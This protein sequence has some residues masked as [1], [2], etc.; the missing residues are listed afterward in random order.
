MRRMNTD[1][2]EYV[3][4]DVETNGLK[5]K[6]DDLLSISFY[7]PDDGKEYNRFL[8]LELNRKIV[9]THIN[10]ITEKDLV[11]ATALTQIEFNHIVDEFELE[12]RIIL[13]YAGGNFDESFLCEYMRRH[14]ISGFE[15]L[16]F[17]NFKKNIISSR[18]SSG[19][20]TKDNLC[21]LFEIKGV[22]AVHSSSN[23]CKLEWEL[24]KKMDGYY[25]LVTE[26]DGADNVFKLNEDYIIP[27]SLLYSHPNLSRILCERP[28]IECKSTTVKTFEIEA[29]GIEKFP[30]NFTGM[31]I[32]HLINSMLN[33]DIQDSRPFLLK[34]KMK[35]DFIGKIPNG[36]LAIPMTF[37]PDGTVTTLNKADKEIEKRINSTNNNLKEQIRPLV[38]FIRN[39][40]FKN[41]HIMSQELVIN[42][43]NNI[44]ALCDLSTTKT[45]L[46]IKTDCSDSLAYKEQ[47]FYEAKGRKIYHLK[48]EWIKDRDTN[49]LKK[50]IFN[51]VLVDVHIGIPDSLNWF[52]GK[53]EG[54]R[55]KRVAE[56]KKYLLSS[57][58]SLVSFKNIST[59]IKLQCKICEYEWNIRYVTLMKKIPD[60]PRCQVK[61]ISKKRTAMSGEERGK[62]R[63]DNYYEKILQKSN[64]TI[65]AINYVGA[66]ENVDA[67]CIT[68]GNKWKSR[69]DHLIDRCW[70]PVCKKIKVLEK[71][72][73]S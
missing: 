22:K 52:E 35:L 19:N 6:Q 18:F 53:R 50:V 1:S 32:E 21:S 73:L 8:P 13:T 25:Y 37:N 9:T 55:L 33:V 69:A 71:E 60:C 5:S 38:D 46:E 29:K 64:R 30:T 44:L 42:S 28:Y 3:V 16:N 47:L 14:Q 45:I 48:M 68:C 58:I 43:E 70:C 20:I 67:I 49:L 26:G 24:F 59:P 7:K 23:D 62:L 66:K 61:I 57:D 11:G 40:I 51:I 15:K 72:P 4:F 54:Q 41:E 65:A 34:N 39:E 17:Y 36:I 12:K 63:A 10:G 31:T 2:T 27:A 56:I